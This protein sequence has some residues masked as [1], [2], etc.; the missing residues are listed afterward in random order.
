MW[1]SSSLQLEAILSAGRLLRKQTNA[2]TQ[3]L[4]AIFFDLGM[5]TVGLDNRYDRCGGQSLEHRQ[6]SALEQMK[7]LP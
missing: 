4:K 7:M 3:F 1:E 6:P 5:K 2:M